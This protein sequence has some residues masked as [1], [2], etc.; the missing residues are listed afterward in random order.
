MS[1]AWGTAPITGTVNGVMGL[2]QTSPTYATVRARPG[3][4]S[5]LGGFLM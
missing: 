4:P 1:H 3:R 5:A 2:A